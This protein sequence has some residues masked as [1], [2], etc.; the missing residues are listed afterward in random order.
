MNVD[1][2]VGRMAMYVIVEIPDCLT[3]LVRVGACF[4]SFAT[5]RVKGVGSEVVRLLITVV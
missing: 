4:V 3:L 5:F 2:A 1:A